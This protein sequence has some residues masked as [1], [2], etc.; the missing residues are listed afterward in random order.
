[1]SL[2]VVPNL[3]LN[4]DAA[5]R[6]T[7]ILHVWMGDPAVGALLVREGGEQNMCPYIGPVFDYYECLEPGTR[8]L[9]DQESEDRFRARVW[10]VVMVERR[11]RK[12]YH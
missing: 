11:K 12:S 3:H 7:G 8:H 4:M 1:M 2:H 10:S 9:S 5:L 6:L